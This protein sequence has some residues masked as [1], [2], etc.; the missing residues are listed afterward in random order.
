[1]KNG[2]EELSSISNWFFP[3]QVRVF[4]VILLDGKKEN[5]TMLQQHFNESLSDVEEQEFARQIAGFLIKQ[6]EGAV[7]SYFWSTNKAAEVE[8][9]WFVSSAKLKINANEACNNIVIFTYDLEL[10]GN[11]KEELYSVLKNL[12]FL[13]KSYY[14]ASLLTKREIEIIVLLADG[15]TSIEIGNELFISNHT[16]NTHRKNINK[17]LKI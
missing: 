14:N 16:V 10:L 12:D 6:E 17:K 15:K 1:M 9:K 5:S 11:F 2:L 3:D 4:D 7:Y 8:E 13:K